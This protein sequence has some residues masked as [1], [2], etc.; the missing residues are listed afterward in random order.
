LLYAAAKKRN[1]DLAGRTDTTDVIA[2]LESSGDLPEAS[3]V[4]A[5][6]ALKYAKDKTT[7]PR[8]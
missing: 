2:A 8:I 7:R 3:Y 5:I 4:H 1:A 6:A